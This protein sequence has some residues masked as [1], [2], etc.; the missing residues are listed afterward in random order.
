MAWASTNFLEKRKILVMDLNSKKTIEGGKSGNFLPLFPKKN[1]TEDLDFDVTFDVISV[2]EHRGY[3][4]PEGVLDVNL[5]ALD[6]DDPIVAG[7]AYLHRFHVNSK[8]SEQAEASQSDLRKFL[9]ALEGVKSEDP[10]FD[11][12]ALLAQ[13]QKGVPDGVKVHIQRTCAAGTNNVRTSYYHVS[14]PE[15]A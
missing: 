12:N 9:A 11:A 13:L 3:K 14:P 1:S 7:R 8:T 2:R 4:T 5:L 10:K 15:A 6:S